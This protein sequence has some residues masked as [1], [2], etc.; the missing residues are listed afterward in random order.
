MNPTRCTLALILA[1]AMG[2]A[3]AQPAQPVP[4]E[5]PC[6]RASGTGMPHD[7]CGGPMHRGPHAA[8]ADTP[9][10]RM[11]TAQERQDHQSRMAAMRDYGECRAYA[12]QHLK[13]MRERATQRGLRMPAH[14]R[15]DACAPLKVEQPKPKR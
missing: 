12:E 13:D 15:R 10:W 3:L 7:H 4:A 2:G 14:A 1:T 8:Q 9:G 5:P 11:M 6:A